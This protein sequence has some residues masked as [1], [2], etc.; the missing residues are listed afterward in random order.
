MQVKDKLIKKVAD[1]LKFEEVVVEKVIAWSFENANKATHH[2]NEIEFS[3]FG[4]IMV[5]QYK[6]KRRMEKMQI[7][8]NSYH[9][10]LLSGETPLLL[11][12]LKSAEEMMEYYK[13]K[14]QNQKPNEDK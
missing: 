6:L 8:I 2:H 14:E 1:E 12:R 5:S 9:Q 10:Q 7:F 4:K 13:M 11:K 3:G